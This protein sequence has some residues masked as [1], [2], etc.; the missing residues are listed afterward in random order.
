MVIC[1]KNSNYF[2]I[3]C[4]ILMIICDKNLNSFVFIC[5]ICQSCKQKS[6]GVELDIITVH[7][8]GLLPGIEL[9]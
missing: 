1:D 9:N 2:V 3:T 7:T 8:S 5:I 6:S 4:I